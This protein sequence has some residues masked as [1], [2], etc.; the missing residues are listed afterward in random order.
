MVKISIKFLQAFW[1]DCLLLIFNNDEKTTFLIDGGIKRAFKNN[2]V[3]TL[4]REYD[5]NLRNYIF[6]THIDDD[7]IGGI[8]VLF[9]RYSDLTNEVSAVFFN[10]FDSLLQLAPN[11]KDNPPTIDINDDNSGLTSYKQGKMLEQKLEEIGIEV[12]SNIISERQ[13]CLDGIQ[14]TFLS[15]SVESLSKYESWSDEQEIAY[16]AVRSNDYTISIEELKDRPFYEDESLTNT[17]SLSVL[18]EYQGKKMLFLGDSLPSDIVSTLNKFGYSNKNRLQ[19]DIVKVSHH[20]SKHNTSNELL[21][22]IS[23]DKFLISTDGRR[24]G[25]PDKETLARIIYSQ[26]CP[27]LIFN[28]D[29][30]NNIFSK[31][32]LQSGLFT[33]NLLH[34][35]IL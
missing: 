1:G 14:L 4:K 9:E 11:A 16:T 13:L 33:V 25:H 12:I 35:V 20:G 6:L 34:E 22:I 2:I 31:E 26:N 19:L 23:C 29:I 7:H 5:Q 28:Y 27:E 24:H 3:S 18:I 32:E 17:S 10:T 15:P 21:E 8:Q 30:Y